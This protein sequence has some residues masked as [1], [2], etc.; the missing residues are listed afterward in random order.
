MVVRPSPSLNWH[1]CQ[2]VPLDE[3]SKDL[4]AINTQKGLYCYN[5]L[6][7]GVASAPSNICIG[8]RADTTKHCP[9][10]ARRGRLEAEE[11]KC[12]FVLP[13]VE[14]LG[15]SISAQSDSTQTK[16]RYVPL[17]KPL[18]LGMFPSY[19]LPGHIVN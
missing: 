15:H 13:S 11:D 17:W 2:Q 10:E 1:V 5:R 4:V 14:Y 19:A 8:D 7:F 12:A 3:E 16:I 6:P 9:E 18:F